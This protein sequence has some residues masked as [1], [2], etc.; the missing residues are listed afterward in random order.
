MEAAGL[1]YVQRDN[2]FT[3]VEDPVKA[4]ALLDQQ[5]HT[6]WAE[7]LNALLQQAHPLHQEIGRPFHQPY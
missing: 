3:W 6:N 7:R 4:Q 1:K 2:C 5:L